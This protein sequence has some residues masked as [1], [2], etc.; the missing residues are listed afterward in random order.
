MK[1]N[2]GGSLDV[3]KDDAENSNGSKLAAEVQVVDEHQP[4]VGDEKLVVKDITPEDGK[5]T[6]EDLDKEDKAVRKRRVARKRKDPG[7]GD[8]TQATKIKK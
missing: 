6:N 2:E 7:T 5:G 3:K 1:D 8:G 4:D